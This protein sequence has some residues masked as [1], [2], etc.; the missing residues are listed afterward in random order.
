VTHYED[1]AVG[2]MTKNA[3]GVPWVS[4]VSLRPLIRY[5]QNPPDR[6]QE[7]RLH[8]RAHH[9][10]FIANSVK[11]RIVVDQRRNGEGA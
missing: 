5:G 8:E 2:V 4:T 11:T 7:Q 10:C 9:G 3:D 6:E 1:E